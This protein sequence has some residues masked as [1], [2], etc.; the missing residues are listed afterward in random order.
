MDAYSDYDDR[1][2]LSERSPLLRVMR[3]DST[4]FEGTYMSMPQHTNG[5]SSE[6]AH[7]R[8]IVYA[9][10]ALASLLNGVLLY[11]L[12]CI[13]GVLVVSLNFEGLLGDRVNWWLVFT[14]FWVANVALFVAHISSLG[15]TRQLRHWAELESMSNEPLLPLLRRIVMIYAVS[16]PLS[17]LLLWSELAFCARLQDPGTGLY[18]CYAPLMVIQV[19]FFVRYLLC[20][21]DSTL[22]GVCWMLMFAFTL[23]LAYETNS[24]HITPHGDRFALSWWTVATPLFVFEG[25]MACALIVVLYHEFSGVYRMTRWQFGASA[26]YLLAL[27]SAVTGQLMLLENIDYHWGT[28]TF[29]SALIFFGLVCASIGMYIVGR[30]HVQELMASKGGAVPVPLTRTNQGWITNHAVTEHWILF[31]DIYLTPEGL[32]Y[33]NLTQGRR[34]SVADLETAPGWKRLWRSV[35][36][37]CGR[38]QDD[39]LTPRDP[40]RRIQNLL[41]RRTS[42]SSGPPSPASSV[43][44]TSSPNREQA[45]ISLEQ[46]GDTTF[47]LSQRN[48]L[49]QILKIISGIITIGEDDLVLLKKLVDAEIGDVIKLLLSLENEDDPSILDTKLQHFLQTGSPAK[50]RVRRHLEITRQHPLWGIQYPLQKIARNLEDLHGSPSTSPTPSS[51]AKTDVIVLVASGAYNP[52]HMLHIRAF[53]VAR[54]YVESNYKFPVV[55]A[56]ISPSHDTYVRAKNRRNPREMITKRHR[57]GLIE[58]AVASSSWI[59]V[60]KWEITRR[61][62]LDYLSTLT[63]VRE[64]CETHFPRFKFHVMYVCG[65][66]SVVKLSHSALRDEGFGCIT[67]CRPTQTEMVMKHLGKTLAKTTTIVEDT[68]VLPCDLERATSFRV[69]QMMLSRQWE[70][71]LATLEMMVGKPALQYLAKHSIPHKVSGR[72]PWGDEDKSWRDADQAYVEYIES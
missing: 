41:R 27:M 62:V 4:S 16:F 71:N 35:R 23:L 59:E 39:L 10:K 46:D 15:H 26:L 60:D 55:G 5:T 54:Q 67:V 57:L 66:N 49:Y 25:L 56:F 9:E 12:C 70:S 29:P 52:I 65:C 24:Q 53:Y 63:H 61:R 20:R 50:H 32:H 69:R 43:I 72:E 45:K 34:N 1:D 58:A 6:Q 48:R 21:S 33:R 44:S 31:G 36:S 37:I 2:S 38:K 3:N 30:H 19:A 68:G 42:D 7:F 22:P 14:P 64:M 11:A 8:P 13:I 40:E 17:V 28:I 51:S 47:A 18:I